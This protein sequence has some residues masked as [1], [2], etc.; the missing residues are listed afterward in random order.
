MVLK[1]TGTTKSCKKCPHRRYYSDGIHECG[2]AEIELTRG[3]KESVPYWCPLQ[4]WPTPQR[5]NIAL[6]VFTCIDHDNLRVGVASVVVARDEAH[7]RTLLKEELRKRPYLDAE[8]P[9][10]LQR[11]D[12]EHPQATILQDGDY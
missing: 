11:V 8:K 10:T 3:E 7:A 6:S 9:F 4:N 1:V 5:R 12:L 2:L